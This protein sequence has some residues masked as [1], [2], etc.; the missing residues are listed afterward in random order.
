MTKGTG[1]VANVGE[2]EN[3]GSLYK[4]IV[5]NKHGQ[6]APWEKYRPDWASHIQKVSV[7][8]RIYEVRLDARSGLLKQQVILVNKNGKGVNQGMLRADD[9]NSGLIIGGMTNKL[10]LM[11]SNF[12]E[13][14]NHLEIRT[15]IEDT[16]PYE[17]FLNPLKEVDEEMYSYIIEQLHYSSPTHTPLEWQQ[18]IRLPHWMNTR[19]RLVTDADGKTVKHTSEHWLLFHRDGTVTFPELEPGRGAHISA[20]TQKTLKMYNA[21]PLAMPDTV[22]KAIK[23]LIGANI[24]ND[25]TKGVAWTLY[26]RNK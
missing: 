9:I 23:I 20:E 21:V 7:G 12:N 18:S 3:D 13:Y 25:E 16:K 15:M 14:I 5:I 4:R 6:Y 1:Y 22:V 17:E 11:Y 24:I 2:D 8:D 19:S 10:N 26:R